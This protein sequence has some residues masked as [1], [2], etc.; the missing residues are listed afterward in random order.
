VGGREREVREGNRR[1]REGYV[2]WVSGRERGVRE[3]NRREERED[4]RS[5]FEGKKVFWKIL[6]K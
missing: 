6:S 1:G 3:G 2:R 5:L 4:V